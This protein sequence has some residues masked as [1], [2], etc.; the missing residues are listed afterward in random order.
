MSKIVD[1]DTV[2][3]S[4]AGHTFH[5]RWAARR[6][7]HLL[8]PKDGLNAIAVEGVSTNETS[9]PGQRAEEVADLVFYYGAGDDFAGCSKLETVQFKYKVDEEPVTAAYLKKTV[10]KFADTI[11]GYDGQ[12]SAAEVDAK[13]TFIFVT[14]APFTES[15]WLA[16]AAVI[17]GSTPSDRGAMTQAQNLIRWCKDR[18]LSDPARLFK[19]T[20]FKAAEESIAAQDGALRR[21]LTDWSISE[22]TEARARLFELQNLVRRKAEPPGQHNNLIQR[23]DVLN[24][25]GCEV[26]DL[27]PAKERFSPV[28]EIISRQELTKAARLLK[29]AL[30][31]FV[32]A[33]GGVGK[34]VFVQSLATMMAGD[35]EVVVFDCFGGGSYR[36]DNHSR[37]LPR[38]GLLQIVNE[39]A[40]KTLCDPILPS[41]DDNR[42]IVRTARR[43]L[44]QAAQAV[45]KQSKKHGVLII[46]D[47][48][49]NAQLEANVR[50]ELSFAKLLLE[51]ID[52]EPVEGVS[53]LLTARPYRKDGVIG[54]TT[55]S[56]IEL[57]PF[58]EPEARAFLAARKPDATDVEITKA[59]TR[60]GRNARVLDYLVQTWN[61]NV[62]TDNAATAITV[63]E[64]IAQRCDKIVND[65]RTA[66]WSDSE[67]GEFFVAISLLPPPIP[68]DELATALGWSISHVLTAASDLAPML[69]RTSHGAIFRDEPTETY[70]RE[71]Y[72]NR[73]HAQQAIAD[74]LLKA[75]STSAYAAE[76]LPHFLVVT[77]DSDRAF[78]LADSLSFPASVQSE[79][80][81]RRLTLARLR[82][83]FRLATDECDY[84]RLIGLSMRLAQVTT[85]NLRGD[86]FIRRAPQLAILLGDADSYRR[87]VADR[88]GWRGAKNARLTIAHHFAGDKD[89][90]KIQAETTIRWINW[91]I[92]QPDDNRSPPRSGP[93]PTDY[94]S[95][96][97]HHAISGAFEIID[98]NLCRWDD[99]FSL[100]VCA[101][102]LRLLELFDSMLVAKLVAFAC[103]E[104][105]QS[106]ILKIQLLNYPRLL[107]KKQVRQLATAIGKPSSI[108]VDEGYVSSIQPPKDGISEIVRASLSA[109][110]YTSRTMAANLLGNIKVDRPSSYDYGERHGPSR[111][112]QPISYIAIRTWSAGKR[113]QFHQLLPS[114]IRINEAAKAV[115]SK[116]E[117]KEFL[118]ALTEPKPAYKL[119]KGER[120]G[121]QSKF[122]SRE[123]EDISE[124]IELALALLRPI[125]EAIFSR[126]GITNGTITVFITVW[127][128]SLRSDIHWGSERSTDM[129][130]RT[131]GLGCLSILLTYAPFVAAAQVNEIIAAFSKGRFSVIQKISVLKQLA[132]LPEH[133][134]IVGQFAQ[135]IAEQ[136]RMDDNVD[137]RGKHYANLAAALI[138]MSFD[139]AKDYYRQGLAQLDQMGGESYDQIYSLLNFAAVQR[140]GFL[141]PPLGQRLMNLCQTIVSNEPSRFEWTLFA[142]AS[143]K[144][145]GY[146]AVHKLVRWH[147]QD[148]AHLSYGLPRLACFLAEF[149]QLAPQRA[150]LILTI[151]EDNS[152]WD[153][154]SGDAVTK[155]LEVSVPED[156]ARIF[157]TILEK[158]KREYPLGGWP[159]LWEGYLSTAS[160]LAHLLS[161]AEIAELETLKMEAQRKQDERD[162]WNKSS[163]ALVETSASRPSKSDEEACIVNWVSKCDVSDAASINTV[164]Q[165]IKQ[166]ENLSYN[167]RNCFLVALRTS[168][169]Y[170]QRLPFLLAVIDAAE[171][172][173]TQSLDII[174]ESIAAWRGSSSHLVSQI[175]RL[176]TLLFNAKGIEIFEGRFS[177]MSRKIRELS[178]FCGNHKLVVN[179]LVRKVAANEVELDG[180]EWLQLA[181]AL[182]EVA[183]GPASLE[184]LQLMLE[185]PASRIADEI[186][187]GPLRSDQLTVTN[188]TDLIADVFWHLLGDTDGYVRWSVARGLTSAVQLGLTTDLGSLIDRFDVQSIPMLASVDHNLSFQNSQQWL[189]M[190]LARA[191]RRE[192]AP[193]QSLRSRLMSLA[194]RSDLHLIHKTHLLRVLRNID[195]GPHDPQVA[196][197]QRAL[198]TPLHGIVVSNEHPADSGSENT[199]S[200]D[201]EFTKSEISDLARR[202]NLT[203]AVIV[204]AMG[205]EIKRIW[206]NATSMD[207]FPER[208]RN[209]WGL[210][211]RHE[212]YREHIQRHALLSAA[213]TLSRKIPLVIRDY[214]IY[215]GSPWIEWRNRFDVTFDDGSWL[216]DRKDRVPGEAGENFLGPKKDR[217]NTLQDQDTILRK[218]GLVDAADQSLVPIYGRWR[219]PE[220]V[221]VR[222]TSALLNDKGVIGKVKDFVKRPASDFWLP[223]CWDGGYYD[224]CSRRETPFAPLIW[225][226]ES[227]GIGI[228]V[229]DELAAEGPASRPRLGIKLTDELGL[230]QQTDDSDW[231]V[232]S[233]TLA[234]RSQV[235]GGWKSDSDHRHSRYHD[236]GE[237]LLASPKWLDDTLDVLKHRLVTTI[238]L[239]KRKSSRDYDDSSSVKLVLVA[240]RQKDGTLRLW[241]AKHASKEEY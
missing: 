91:Y 153:W 163:H 196:E 107:S 120:T 225:V 207:F 19:R 180:D 124:N 90:A 178:E 175:E 78:A 214:Q 13:A 86:G 72:A 81:R 193:L 67:V 176:A 211:D 209:R 185:G 79:F 215:E 20:V 138:S 152:S 31:V 50:G 206:P 14:N 198:D 238:T 113:L 187:E 177:N 109:L 34:T 183:S 77:K 228:D 226:P 224:R 231:F 117:A 182:C 27:F 170:K 25:L 46:I 56:E 135:T 9:R 131:V 213:T 146:P 235:W 140:G 123:V 127:V 21:T 10:E 30:P 212:F 68:L 83:A 88:S 16:I 139:E 5:E 28:G 157:R 23:E 40:A 4:R 64:I 32:H 106:R 162:S 8:F 145:I 115:S 218:L 147:D 22:D 144:S 89:E 201:Y 186:G 112:W 87:L 191:A 141:P 126:A 57:G 58:T 130:S 143:A 230:Q 76:A 160:K 99:R 216:S 167:T 133:G 48:A 65:L 192:S 174:S 210:G 240:L 110:V 241:H 156:Q 148:I 103:T 95:V 44:A 220:G 116:T 149:G 179:L 136:I 42:K 59:L 84:D 219:S 101:Q 119:K 70:V 121:I 53:L 29:G 221:R 134:E 7:L 75:Q 229:G 122:S 199:F 159:S 24:A 114:K 93:T 52:E 73:P 227:Y 111:I 2:R 85:A 204:E 222:I 142:R 194:Q 158:L 62:A 41:S 118:R 137:Q 173:F 37:H 98:R 202:F 39:L 239:W 208:S 55:V 236:D 197:M 203:Q 105:C 43:R 223:E 165:E 94:V 17:D 1:N 47:A 233:D 161:Q 190:G 181:T 18:K 71:T 26:E 205:Q 154:K 54:R 200:F 232:D 96:L 15:L 36:S 82:S 188:E 155:L 51:A 33:D 234:L 150:A 35:F 60:S 171:I 128:K 189:L 125:E 6:A 151:L 169:A 129:L 3:A 92:E 80:G 74:R 166:A 45:K 69:E 63:P 102:F 237:I 100:S 172:S 66:G 195:G 12:F 108:E 217:Q 49:D 104:K 164:L 184:A 11:V 132:R 168:C 97:F 38:I 61:L